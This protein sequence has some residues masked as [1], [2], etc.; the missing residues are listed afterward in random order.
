MNKFKIITLGIVALI[1]LTTVGVF[2]VSKANTPKNT[3]ISDPT[4]SLIKAYDGTTN[5]KV[6]PG[7]LNNVNSSDDVKV[8]AQANYDTAAIGQSKTI[9]VVYTLEGSDADKYVAPANYTVSTGLI[10]AAPL[11]ISEP[12]LTITKS[13]DGTASAMVTPGTL[14]GIVG[15]ENVT[16]TATAVY[17]SS[18]IGKNKTI[19]VIYVL[20]GANAANYEAPM[21][22]TVSNGEI[23]A[24]PTATSTSVTTN[25]ANT[26]TSTTSSGSN[27]PAATAPVTTTTPAVTNPPVTTKPD[28]TTSA[29][30]AK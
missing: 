15:S 7:T 17:N 28:T 27:P 6:T 16:V 20:G 29:T 5:A 8:N 26:T 30:A 25:T 22:D 9:T 19:T 2:A 14:T 24:V 21:S 3:T 1:V 18:D 11:I 4:L 10:K 13:Y 23:T 12:K